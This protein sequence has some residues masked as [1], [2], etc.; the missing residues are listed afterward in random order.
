MFGVAISTVVGKLRITLSSGVAPQAAVTALQTSS[1]KSSSVAVKVSGLY[2]STH[3]VSGACAASSLINLN[4]GDRH[5]DHFRAA[6]L[7]N[8]SRGNGLDVAL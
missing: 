7:E 2:S 4:G 5:V 8:R 1:A 6:H 3:S